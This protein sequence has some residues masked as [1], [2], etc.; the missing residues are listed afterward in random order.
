MK[1]IWIKNSCLKVDYKRKKPVGRSRRRRD[2][3]IKTEVQ[4]TV[5]DNV[6]GF[7]WLRIWTTHA[8]LLTL[9]SKSSG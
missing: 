4:E 8:F 5:C 2:N 3:S 1:W 9:F 6:V 7:M